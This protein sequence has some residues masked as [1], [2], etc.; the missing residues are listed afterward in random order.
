MILVNAANGNQGKLLVPRLIAAGQQVRACVRT[1]R[2]GEVLRAAGV[3][4]V[5]V[6]DIADPDVAARA[7]DG[8]DKV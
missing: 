4:E 5:I 6:G 8:A 1:E 2:S 3:A 7:M